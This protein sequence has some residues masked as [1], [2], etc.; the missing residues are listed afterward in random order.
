MQPRSTSAP[1]GGASLQPGRRDAADEADE[2]ADRQVEVVAG[3]DE[4]LRHRR[5]RDRD[6]QIQHQREAEIADRARV[7]PGDRRD[8]ERQRQ[9][10]Q[11]RAEPAPEVRAVR[12]D[13][14]PKPRALMSRDPGE[15]GMDDALL[16]Q[17][18]ARRARRRPRRCG[19]HRCGRSS[20]APPSRSCTRGRSARRRLGADEL[21][22]LDLGAVV[23]AAHRI[24][25]QHDARVGGERAGEQRLL[26]I[27]ARERQDVVAD[28]GRADP[29]P[30][31]PGVGQ[32]RLGRVAR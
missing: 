21:V 8:D 5:E 13:R 12:R 7:Q 2:G 1:S 18:V 32:L 23:D 25:H 17:F 30:L 9:R 28:V 11:R 16:R 22:D 29:D 15:R 20:S 24:V 4:H 3:D 26:L 19:R 10:R 14:P 27:A 31:A 6:R